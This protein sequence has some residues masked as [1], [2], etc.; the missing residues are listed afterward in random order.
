[1]S[2]SSCNYFKSIICNHISCCECSVILFFTMVG[3]YIGQNNA[4]ELLI[5]VVLGIG[6]T[7]MRFAD[8]PLAPLLIGFILGLQL[9]LPGV[10]VK[11]MYPRFLAYLSYVWL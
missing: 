3:A 4:T 6:A 11:V 10:E 9:I 2:T 7:I 1:M 5:L 8:Y